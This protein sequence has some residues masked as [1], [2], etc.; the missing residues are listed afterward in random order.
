MYIHMCVYAYML[1]ETFVLVLAS[2][3]V[4]IYIFF[5]VVFKFQNF[6][7]NFY[8]KLLLHVFCAAYF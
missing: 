1:A 3:L 2:Y 4:Y 5:A 8:L 7:H 6:L